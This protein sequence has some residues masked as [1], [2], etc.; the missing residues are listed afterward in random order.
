MSRKLALKFDKI[1]YWSEIKLEIITDYATAYSTIFTAKRQ[2]RFHH[3][4]I[5][6]FAGPGM[7][8][9][10]GTGEFV[11]GSPLNALHVEP[12]FREYHFIELDRRKVVELKR[13]VGNRPDVYIHDGDCNNILLNEVFPNVRFENFRRGLCLFD[14]YGLH[15]NWEVI[16]RAGQM[17]SIDIFLNFPVADMN[18]N[19]LWR[20]P[21]GLDAGDLQRMNAFWGDESW[22]EIAYTTV[23][24]LFGYP[25]KEDNETIAEAFR[26]RL[27]R[28]AGFTHV[29]KPLPMRNSRRAIVYY[30][31]FASQNAAG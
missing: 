23:R 21:E 15:L 12:R 8:I 11:P 10:K 16:E 30:L 25:E 22:R 29:P 19:V 13:A 24:D 17:K 31:F 2:R 5:D 9:S 20:H 7:H 1:G 27:Q 26:Q 4:Y 14:P 28:V 18:R 6:A 3:V